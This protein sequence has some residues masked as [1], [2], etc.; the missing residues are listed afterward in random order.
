MPKKSKEVLREIKWRVFGKTK[1]GKVWQK[2]TENNDDWYSTLFHD[3]PLLHENF[4]NFLK[5]KNISNCLEVGCGTGIYPIKF[6][7]LFSDIRYT[8]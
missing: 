2:S 8:G 4:I 1:Y 3:R 7:H 5:N 6:K